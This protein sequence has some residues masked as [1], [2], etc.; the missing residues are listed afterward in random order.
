MTNTYLTG[1]P[2]GSMAPKDLFD[3]ASNFDDFSLSPLPSFLDRF[4]KRRK[5]IAGMEADFDAFLVSSGDVW[6]GDYAAGLVFSARNQYMVRDGILYRIAPGVELPYT[7][8]GNWALEQSNFVVIKSGLTVISV[9]DF[10]VVG[11]GVTNDGPALNNAIA[12]MRS[13]LTDTSKAMTLDLAGLTCATDVSIDATGLISWGWQI[14]NG[15]IF[16]RCTGKA[17][18]DMIGS[19]GGKI[20]LVIDG[21]PVNMPSVGI[22]AARSGT[23]Q[24]A[25][26]DNMLWNNVTTQG[27][28]SLAGVHTY[29]QETTTYNHCRFWNYNKDGL[30]AIHTGY[31]SFPMASDY[32]TPITGATSYINNKY[33][34]CDYRYLPVAG[35]GAITNITKANP[36]VVTSAGHPFVNGDEIVIGFVAG[37][38]EVN[39][40]TATVSGVTADT[41]NLVGVNSTGY[42]AYTSGGMAIASQTVPTVYF[43]RGEQ[44]HF[45]TCYIVNYGNHSLQVDFIDPGHVPKSLWLDVLFEGIGSISHVEFTNVSGTKV[46]HDFKLSTYNMHCRDY[47]MGHTGSGLDIVSMYGVEITAQSRSVSSAPLLDLYSKF[48]MYDADVSTVNTGMFDPLE[49][50]ANYIGVA[51]WLNGQSTSYNSQFISYLDGEYTPTIASTLGAIGSYTATGYQRR[52]GNLVFFNATI[53]VSDNGTGAGTLVFTLP[54]ESAVDAIFAGRLTTGAGSML[55][56]IASPGSV[57]CQVF[58]YDN[59]YPAVSGSVLK[60]SGSYVA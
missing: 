19:R 47:L 26:C 45:D 42:G 8:T 51:S 43:A 57:Q 5:T 44:H 28:F 59:S 46:M 53:T 37:M 52:V 17:V 32:M 9:K 30:A 54:T 16:G 49:M 18:L 24:Y 14:V 2:L 40:I 60:M 55:Q 41:F 22:Q 29:G 13:K 6:I 3:N 10:G 4:S 12:Y 50:G 21:D 33:I 34:N 56:G 23:A 36:A 39:N 20:D 27:F 38:T 58:K 15:T 48:A 7:T 31:S 25:F 35:I 1:N 11:D